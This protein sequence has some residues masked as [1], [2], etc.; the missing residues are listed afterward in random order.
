MNNNQ[1]EKDHALE[2]WIYIGVFSLV[3]FV[4]GLS[5]PITLSVEYAIGFCLLLGLI[6]SLII[7]QY[8]IKQSGSLTSKLCGRGENSNCKAIL[9][10]PKAKFF[11]IPHADI[12]VIYF[13]GSLAI[14]VSVIISSVSTSATTPTP[15]IVSV[16]SILTIAY[17]IY[18]IYCQKIIIKKWCSLCLLTQLFVLAQA[19]IVI[20]NHKNLAFTPS[21]NDI[22]L[23]GSILIFLSI[24]L[25]WSAIRFFLVSINGN[26]ERNKQA[27]NNLLSKDTIKQ[28]RKQKGQ[29]DLEEFEGDIVIQHSPASTTYKTKEPWHVVIGI[30]PSCKHCGE[31][32]EQM[33]SLVETENLPIKLRIRFVTFY[34]DDQ[35][36]I[37]D[38]VVAE[39]TIALNVKEGCEFAL[40]KL[41]KWYQ[42]FDGQDLKGWE[43]TLRDLSFEEINMS[44]IYIADNSFW[45]QEK[46]IT[47]TPSLYIEEYEV[48]PE[49]H[50]FAPELL[51]KLCN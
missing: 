13:G 33:I 10:N 47:K 4:L 48:T 21:L 29:F 16:L 31:F 42:E 39:S 11:G 15:W 20:I 3:A 18:S 22:S 24:I 36:G 17:S 38:R 23:L 50:A 9:D 43:A 5:A 45:L 32:L 40:E 1:P 46:N 34:G 30:A 28:I 41:R 26:T 44:G 37:N 14:L 8:Y 49:H 35:D 27:Q 6:L 51:R 7:S 12:G 25:V 2:Y 19:M